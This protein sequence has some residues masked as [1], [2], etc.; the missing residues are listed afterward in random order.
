ME[1]EKSK[2]RE[3]EREKKTTTKKTPSWVRAEEQPTV[4]RGTP[5]RQEVHSC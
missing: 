4:N 5:A 1:P 3:R 2:K